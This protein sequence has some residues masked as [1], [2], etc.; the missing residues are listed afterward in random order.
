MVELE[1][2]GIRRKWGGHLI[3]V[4]VLSPSAHH[5]SEVGLQDL[6]GI[7]LLVWAGS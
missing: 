2:E 5:A 1:D 3:L 7:S 4:R 6:L